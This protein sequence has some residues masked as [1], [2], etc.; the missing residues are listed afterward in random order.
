MKIFNFTMPYD[1]ELIPSMRK[2]AYNSY[3]NKKLENW[4]CDDFVTYVFDH[5]NSKGEL[6][7]EGTFFNDTILQYFEGMPQNYQR[8]YLYGVFELLKSRM[9]LFKTLKAK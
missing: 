2:P 7:A 9:N 8:V 4:D 3:D 6:V 5:Q 1:P